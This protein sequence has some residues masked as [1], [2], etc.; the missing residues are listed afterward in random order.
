MAIWN[1]EVKHIKIQHKPILCCPNP[2]YTEKCQGL[3]IKTRRWQKE[4]V[5]CMK[6]HHTIEHHPLLVIINPAP[7]TY[8]EYD[9]L[10][11]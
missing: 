5:E 1:L 6:V 8:K 4:C 3:Y 11:I 9:I 2:Q 10:I 7:L